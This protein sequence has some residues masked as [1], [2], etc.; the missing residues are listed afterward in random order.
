V[1]TISAHAARAAVHVRDRISAALTRPSI[2]YAVVSLL[3][4]GVTA[5]WFHRLMLNLGDAVLYGPNDA[6]YG[7]RQYWGAEFQGETP[8]TQERDVLNGAPEG[9]PIASAVQIA[10]FLIPGAIWTMHYAVG[11]TAASNL[12]LLGGFVAT[13]VAFFVLLDRLG[14]HPFA[15]FF[16]G[17]ALAFNPWMMERAGAGHSGFMQAW[18]FPLVVA[19]LL[20][21]Y[22]RRTILSAVLVG[23]GLAFALYDNSYY[24][25]MA[26]LVVG[27]FWLVE[28]WRQSSW[29]ERLWTATLVD[30]AIVAAVVAY[31][32]PLLAWR[33][34]HDTVSANVSNAVA[35]VQSLGAVAEA[36]FLPGW[37][38]PYLSD[39][40]HHFVPDAEFIWAEN[41][42]YLGYSL[43]VLGL[44]GAWL[45]L[46]RH[47]ATYERPLLRVFLVGMAVLAP[48]AFLFSLKR[49]TSVFGVDV[50]MPSY[51]VSEFTAFWRVF[52]RFALLV[53]FALAGLAALALS[54][55]IRR[56]RHGMAIA[57]GLFALLAFEYYKGVL[58][59]YELKETAYSQWIE[60][61]PEGIVANYPLPTD[62][63]A[64]L[65]LLSETFFQQTYNETPQFALFG[66]GYGGTREDAIRIVSRYVTDPETPSMLKANGVKYVLLH[67]DVY[68]EA[69]DEPPPIPAGFHLI[70][71]IP[72]NVRALAIDDDVQ[73]AEIDA[74]LERNAAA[75]A[76]VQGITAPT[77][78]QLDEVDGR[79]AIE[80][81]WDHPWLRRVNLIVTASTIGRPRKL[82]LYNEDGDP[83]GA[84]QLGPIP[85]Q[86][87]YGPID[88]DGDTERLEFRTEPDG[89]VKVVGIGAQP[90]A[91][92]SVSIRDY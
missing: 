73:P 2:R 5:L 40:T 63:P 41:T 69:G 51:V 80:L 91:D 12:Y 18:I 13:G 38:H 88:V 68:R 52:A 47:P 64:A 55:L 35:H 15:A 75:I 6:S 60:R 33:S 34:Q 32:P 65:R 26:A 90:L 45:V 17:Y 72:G 42:L 22:R 16:G 9:L 81:K 76:A 61:Q 85:D 24:G 77:A 50:P 20:H 57:V 25:L 82:H 27:V 48:V 30:V 1:A 3:Y 70:D 86:V 78:T 31:I 19:L 7:I 11:F 71:R 83:L 49:E 29:R 92:F 4:A 14:L 79:A 21:Q 10:N 66:S 58:P 74:T 28:F 54:V 89:R 37:R 67:D 59:V 43:L 53:T 84:F 56:V 46:R 44:V 39:I 36:Y 23:L 8:F 62:N 87:I